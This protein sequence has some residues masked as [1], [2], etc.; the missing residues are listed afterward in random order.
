[1]N[2]LKAA[3]FAFQNYYLKPFIRSDE[4]LNRPLDPKSFQVIVDGIARATH[5]AMH[6]SRVAAYV[7]VIHL[8]RE[9]HNDP[10][11]QAL[12]ELA[13]KVNFTAIDLLYLIQIAGIFHDAA[14]ENECEDHWDR[15]S[16]DIC[17]QFLQQASFPE[18][19]AHL[20]ANT[21]RYKDD[22]DRFIQA[23]TD[24]GFSERMDYLRQLVH[25]AD[26]LDIMRVRKTFKMQFLDL[27]QAAD[28]NHASASILSLVTEIRQLIHQQGDQY[29]DCEIQPHTTTLA[30]PAL[31]EKYFDPDLKRHYELADDV[32]ETVVAD[33]NNY[34]ELQRIYR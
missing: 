31:L 27:A 11:A 12:I 15:Q 22:K 29:K 16:A 9:D 33:M 17:F 23:A 28:L 19:L 8:F 2:L 18:E 20:I 7:K 30:N 34:P 25:D 32:Y 1:M 5:G 3:N 6:S 13:A 21:I 10:A 24:L 4:T 26:C 14:R